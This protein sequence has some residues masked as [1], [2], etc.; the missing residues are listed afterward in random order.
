MVQSGELIRAQRDL[1]AGGKI[2][3]WSKQPKR[4]AQQSREQ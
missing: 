1:P 2:A 4:G 3:L